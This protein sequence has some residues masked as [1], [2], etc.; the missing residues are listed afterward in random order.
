[1]QGTMSKL[2]H[3]VPQTY[4][5]A[6]CFSGES[7]HTYD[8]ETKKLLNRNISTILAENYFHSIKAGSL[9]TTPKALNKI[10]ESLD[11]YTVK[12]NGKVLD[13]KDEL[14]QN[15][16]DYDEWEITY[17]NGNKVSKK[18]RNEIKQQLISI[19]DDTLEKRWSSELE[20]G[21]PSIS[22]NLYTRLHKILIKDPDEI[23][24]FEDFKKLIKYFIMFDWRGKNSNATL[25]WFMDF[26]KD[27]FPFDKSD[28]VIPEEKRIY[29]SDKTVFDEIKHAAMLR[30]Y[31]QLLDNRDGMKR[32]YESYLANLTI[33]F[34][35]DRN[36]DLITSD[37]PAYETVDEN[38]NKVPI[39]VATPKVL[40]MLAKKDPLEPNAYKIKQMD[41]QEVEYYN[42]KTF[43]Q[44]SF[45]ISKKELN[46]Q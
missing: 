27:I 13:S 4:M 37:N 20:N 11:Q 15:F 45:I 8:K 42:N 19:S 25:N 32:I 35:L 9:Y 38:G 33:I 44:A 29:R 18:K 26:L 23:L 2:H 16:Q 22:K 24:T 34:L 17:P 31:E 10:F 41:Q 28:M 21:W 14:N 39:F 36:S 6:W 46:I 40:I 5:R 30:F 1:M 7:V 43:E 12:L 3:K